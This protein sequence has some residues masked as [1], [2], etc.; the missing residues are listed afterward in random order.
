[1]GLLPKENLDKLMA[2][3]EERVQAKEQVK[4]LLEG[5]S[6]ERYQSLFQS[7]KKAIAKPPSQDDRNIQSERRSSPPTDTVPAQMEE[8]SKP[9]TTAP[10]EKSER[11]RLRESRRAERQAKEEKEEK[12]KQAQV[13]LFNSFFQQPPAKSSAKKDE[14][15]DQKTDFEKTFLPC[16]FKN[17]A[18]P[19]KF[20]HPVDDSL[21][22]ELDARTRSLSGMSKM[23]TQNFSRNSSTSTDAL[24]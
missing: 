2:R 22:N 21:L 4:E 5:M 11:T 9:V 12:D 20:Y 6:L 8:A 19:N 1:L 3:R 10:K 14:D 16:E 15:E 17:M 13:R 18:E 24:R 7:K 23:L